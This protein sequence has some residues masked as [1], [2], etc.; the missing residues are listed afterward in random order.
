MSVFRPDEISWLRIDYATLAGQGLASV[1]LADAEAC[2]AWLGDHGYTLVTID[3]GQGFRHVLQ[4]INEVFAWTKQFGYV[5][6]G[7]SLDAL[8]DGFDPHVPDEGG[9][10]LELSRPDLLFEEEPRFTLGF[11]AIAAESSRRYMAEGKRF[12]T[13]LVVPP[14]SGILGEVVDQVSVPS[15]FWRPGPGSPFRGGG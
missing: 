11:L 15:P 13:L 6:E 3:C 1:A 14:R 10:V 4:C 7:K 5:Y 9:L 2:R 12:F 8:R